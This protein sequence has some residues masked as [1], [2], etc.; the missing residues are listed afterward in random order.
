VVKCVR[1]SCIRSRFSSRFVGRDARCRRPEH[2][3]QEHVHPM[4]FEAS[5]CLDGDFGSRLSQS[6]SA[7]RRHWLVF[8]TTGAVSRG[9][10]SAVY[11]M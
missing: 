11:D 1:S 4:S 5:Y 10:S 7:K 2:E 6:E 9:W 3:G 8:W